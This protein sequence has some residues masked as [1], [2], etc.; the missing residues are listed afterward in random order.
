MVAK[1]SRDRRSFASSNGASSSGK[2]RQSSTTHDLVQKIAK[3][4]G[5]CSFCL[6][7]EDKN[8]HGLPEDMIHCAECGNSGR[9]T[10]Q[11]SMNRWS[12]RFSRSSVMFTLFGQ[13]REENS[14]TPMA[15]P[16]LQ[17][18]RRLQERR[19]FRMS[20]SLSLHSPL[21]YPRPFFSYFSATFVMLQ[22]TRDV[23][24][25]RYVMSPKVTSPVTIAGQMDRMPRKEKPRQAV[26]RRSS[27]VQWLS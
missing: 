27:L 8:A 13:T 15:V 1:G 25:H 19:R 10:N 22:F 18:L 23:Q 12:V 20:F 3:P 4:M 2:Q 16:G 26:L 24:V 21:H 11:R 9:R 5:V 6:G 7:D 17:T 14:H